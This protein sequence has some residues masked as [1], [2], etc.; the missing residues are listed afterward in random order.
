MFENIEDDED[1]GEI[2]SYY[3]EFNKPNVMW[4]SQQTDRANLFEMSK[5]SLF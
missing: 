3:R 4:A 2:K 1:E 5:I